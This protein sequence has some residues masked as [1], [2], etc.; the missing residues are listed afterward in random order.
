M[1]EK[2]RKICTIKG[3]GLLT[4][5][6]ILAETNGFALFGNARQLVSFAGLDVEENQSGKHIGNTRITKKGN[7][8][9]RRI[10]YMPA[11]VTVTHQVKP[12]MDLYQRTLSK[13]GIKMKSYVAVQKKLLVVIY[14]L[15]KKNEAFDSGC[16][17]HEHTE[18]QESALPLGSAAIAAEEIFPAEKQVVPVK[19]PALHKVSMPSERSPYA[20]S[21][22]VQS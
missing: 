5:A 12:F 22:V 17:L 6:T 3:V 20:S 1:A 9:I 2:V 21:R 14:A 7:S 16:R 18:E 19:L 4:A 8:H 11:F 13:H 15:W 10:L